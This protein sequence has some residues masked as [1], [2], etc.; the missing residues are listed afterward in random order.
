VATSRAPAGAQ[1]PPRPRRDYSVEDEIEVPGNEGPEVASVR[2]GPSAPPPE[3]VWERIPEEALWP[4]GEQ[5]AADPMPSPD[6]YPLVY[7]CNG[8]WVGGAENF[9][10]GVPGVPAGP[11]MTADELAQMIYARLAG[12]LPAPVVTSVP[13]ADEA[14]I[15]SFPTFVSVS[16]WS[17]VVEDDECDPTGT[18]CVSVTATPSLTFSPGEPKAPTIACAGSGT[19]L[20]E[21]A[22]SSV[23]LAAQPGACAYAYRMRTGVGS[24]PAAWPGVVTVTWELFWSS[25]SGAGG[26][27]PEVVGSTGVPRAVHEVQT[28]ID[29]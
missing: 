22:S 3:C 28:V 5:I 2:S 9:R 19:S 12:D 27:L 13:A 18:L 21:A 8:V 23:A 4:I 29:R 6:A 25:T 7:M 14:A 1:E 16:N 20:V 24:R 15:V 11:V 10:W 26:P 17:G